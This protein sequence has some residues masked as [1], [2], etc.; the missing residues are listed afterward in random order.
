MKQGSW[1]DHLFAKGVNGNGSCERGPSGLRVRIWCL[2]FSLCVSRLLAVLC[3][4]AW[5]KHTWS[6]AR[7]RAFLYSLTWWSS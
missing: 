7:L 5:L 6:Q 2:G 1:S 4:S 3:L